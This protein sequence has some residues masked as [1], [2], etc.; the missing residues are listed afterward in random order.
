MRL[1]GDFFRERLIPQL[2]VQT[3]GKFAGN[4]GTAA[5]VLALQ[6]DDSEHAILPLLVYRHPATRFCPLHQEDHREHGEDRIA[7]DVEIVEVSQ[8][9]GLTLQHALH[10]RV[11]L[12]GSIGRTGAV[13]D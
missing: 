4:I 11:G 3:V 2:P 13:R 5:A 10:D 8:H 6:G 12:F 1:L 9:G 7:Q